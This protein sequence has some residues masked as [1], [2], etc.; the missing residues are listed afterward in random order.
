M[1][2]QNDGEY[3]IGAVA[4]F[5]S[6]KLRIMSGKVAAR[7][8]EY[9]A[10]NNEQKLSQIVL[11]TVVYIEQLY[12]SAESIDETNRCSEFI[13]MAVFAV[14][15]RMILK[16]RVLIVS[17]NPISNSLELFEEAYSIKEND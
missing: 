6:G 5:I 10:D 9:L 1:K 4:A 14:G 11:E 17:E 15:G 8:V 12:D 2:M 7:L 13:M 16:D 3:T